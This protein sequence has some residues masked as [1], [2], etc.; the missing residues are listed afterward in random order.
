MTLSR[1]KRLSRIGMPVL[2][3]AALAAFTPVRAEA[4]YY[5]RGFGHRGFGFHGSFLHSHFGSPFFYHSRGFYGPYYRP[6]PP[7]GLDRD[8]ARQLGFGGL[9]LNVKPKKT[10]VY[11][12]G[13]YV[14]VSGQFD[15]LPAY[16]WL[17][18]V[19]HKLALVKD[20]YKTLEREYKITPGAVLDVRLKLQEGESVPPEEITAAS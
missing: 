17:K 7:G 1:I 3:L 5:H 18:E 15:G 13:E 9:D 6:A 4:S 12:D 14:G 19:T 10:E 8:V 20:G 16:L 2:M 11:V